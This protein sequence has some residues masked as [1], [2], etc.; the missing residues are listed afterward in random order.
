MR[1]EDKRA[2]PTVQQVL[3][4][5][6]HIGVEVVARLVQNEHVGLVK[7]REEQGEATTL[8]TR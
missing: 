4:N 7:N 2:G 5:R 3:H 1:H 8:A 6:K